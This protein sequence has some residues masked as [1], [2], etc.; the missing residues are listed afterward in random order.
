VLEIPCDL[1]GT[2]VQRHQLFSDINRLMESREFLSRTWLLGGVVAT[3]TLNTIAKDMRL[4]DV[5]EGEALNLRDP[6][7]GLLR[8]G[9]VVRCLGGEVLE[10]LEAGDFF[11]EETAVFDAPPIATLRTETRTQIYMISPQ[12]LAGIPNVR[13]K[14]FETFERRSRMET[15]GMGPGGM[16]MAWHDEFCV[17][18]QTIDT[19]HRRLFAT[20]NT[21]L[22]VINSGSGDAEIAAAVEFLFDYAKHHFAEE[23][24]LLR[25]TGYPYAD[26]H[27][28]RHASLIA[29]LKELEDELKS[30]GLAAAALL[31]FLH[32]W[33]VNHVLVED[34]KFAAHLNA[35]GVN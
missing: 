9:R 11:G 31:D 30:G 26:A 7:V 33:L 24:A 6:T 25:R 23:E 21:L 4:V 34:R 15:T 32:G 13:W 19:Q 20:A 1:Y 10:T 3:G 22:D 2:F 35:R 14:L 5:E 8:S 28:E 16:M 18:V 27:A 29:T 12:L 17:N